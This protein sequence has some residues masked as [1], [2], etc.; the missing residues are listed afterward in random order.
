[1]LLSVIRGTAKK[2]QGTDER[3][4]LYKSEQRDR[5]AI[6]EPSNRG[7]R[8]GFD[9]NLNLKVQTG[10]GDRRRGA[11]DLEVRNHSRIVARV[12]VRV[13]TLTKKQNNEP[14]EATSSQ[15]S[16]NHDADS[17]QIMTGRTE[18]GSEDCKL[19]STVGRT[20]TRFSSR[21]IRTP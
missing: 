3:I 16:S 1:M 8:E 12:S 5:T 9:G 19:V 20:Q 18:I 6:A 2:S 11:V 4:Q 15:Q 13:P 10:F 14:N 17:D 21:D 7:S